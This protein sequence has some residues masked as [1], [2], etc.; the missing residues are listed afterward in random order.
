VVPWRHTC[1][2][3]CS[4][5]LMAG[6][7]HG[8]PSDNVITVV[9]DDDDDDDDVFLAVDLE[10]LTDGAGPAEPSG[11]AVLSAPPRATPS[12]PS[13]EDLRALRERFGHRSFK[14]EQ[15]EMIS[16]AGVRHPH[17]P[18]TSPRPFPIGHSLTSKHNRYISFDLTPRHFLGMA[19]PI[20]T[21]CFCL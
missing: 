16:C 3:P 2:I 14:P 11:P 13:A 21:R 9:D 17:P 12:P 6:E 7:G 5:A 18:T 19:W 4:L 20:N 8:P 15:W 10:L 1:A